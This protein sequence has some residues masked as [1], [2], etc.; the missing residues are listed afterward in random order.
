MTTG[1]L[2][3]PPKTALRPTLMVI[4]ALTLTF[5]TLLT[6]LALTLSPNNTQVT[7]SLHTANDLYIHSTQDSAQ[8]KKAD[9]SSVNTAFNTW[10]ETLR[11]C[12]EVEKHL[13]PPLNLDDLKQF[14]LVPAPTRAPQIRPPRTRIRPSDSNPP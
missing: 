9:D 2:P 11:I 3:L 5:Q 13:P 14:I 4:L 1:R 8:Q 6:L 12:S 7:T 10:G